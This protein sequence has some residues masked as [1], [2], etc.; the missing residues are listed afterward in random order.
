MPIIMGTK[1][2]AS[3]INRRDEHHLGCLYEFNTEEVVENVGRRNDFIL[4]ARIR[5]KEPALSRLYEPQAAFTYPILLPLKVS[6][7]NTS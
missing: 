7:A 4:G 2:A 1:T 5:R 3:R 6:R